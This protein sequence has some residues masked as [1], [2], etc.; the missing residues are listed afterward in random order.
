MYT[1]SM[2]MLG[3]LK[4]MLGRSSKVGGWGLFLRLAGSL[5]FAPALSLWLVTTGP[6]SELSSA[7]GEEAA[8][9]EAQEI[10]D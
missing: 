4:C 6:R 1:E 8:G 5:T 2:E 10:C 7:R 9:P 3:T